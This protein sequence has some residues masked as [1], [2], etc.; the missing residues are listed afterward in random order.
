MVEMFNYCNIIASSSL[1]AIC[2]DESQDIA[3]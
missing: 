1:I 2:S 3:G